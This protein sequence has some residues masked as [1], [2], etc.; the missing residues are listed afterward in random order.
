MYKTHMD[1]LNQM[2]SVLHELAELKSEFNLT[3]K[4]DSYSGHDLDHTVLNLLQRVQINHLRK[5]L[6]HFIMPL[7]L[8]SNRSPDAAM[9][10]YIEFLVENRKFTG[11][12][13]EKAVLVIEMLTNE[14]DRLQLSLLVLN[15]APVPWI[16]DLRPLIGYGQSSHPL[17]AEIV[18]KHQLQVVKMIRIRYDYPANTAGN[19]DMQLVYRIVRLGRETMV[20][21]IQSIVKLM[22]QLATDICVYCIVHLIQHEQL[23]VAL[24]FFDDLMAA[25]S[26]KGVEALFTRFEIAFKTATAMYMQNVVHLLK[27]IASRSI[28]QEVRA[29]IDDLNVVYKLRSVYGIKLGSVANLAEKGECGSIIPARLIE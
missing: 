16:D 3:I 26:S 17:A 9:A 4:L 1:T 22:P 10:H 14:E 7:F 23:E 5:L 11:Q 13:Q 21:E 12:W 27:I 6:T 20:A 15:N 28:S 8:K 24:G 25:S 2:L 29:S 18:A 19:N